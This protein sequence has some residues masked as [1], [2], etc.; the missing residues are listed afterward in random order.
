MSLVDRVGSVEEAGLVGVRA[1]MARGGEVAPDSAV[2]SR[3]R[4]MGGLACRARMA[5]MVHQEQLAQQA[6]TVSS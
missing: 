1:G 4:L 5:Q 3:T 2:V 6:T